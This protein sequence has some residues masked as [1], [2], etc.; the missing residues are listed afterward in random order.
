MLV[1]LAFRD[2]RSDT[3]YGSDIGA[4]LALRVSPTRDGSRSG[5]AIYRDLELVTRPGACF[6]QLEEL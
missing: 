5:K 3:R 1:H 4:A 2:G 6:H